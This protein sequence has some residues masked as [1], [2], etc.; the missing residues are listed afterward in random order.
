MRRATMKPLAALLATVPVLLS[1]NMVHPAPATTI[2]LAHYRLT[3]AED[4]NDLSVSPWADGHSRWIA[5]TPWAGDFGDAPFADPAP[6]FPFTLKD[7]VLR[8]E[9]RKDEA[10]AWRAGL[11]S[12][13]DDK[14]RGFCQ[15][16][17]YFE[18][19]MKLPP[20]PG[21]WP[22][23]WLM[24]RDTSQGKAEID[25]M[26]YYGHNNGQIISTWHVWK[27]QPGQSDQG[28][29]TIVAVPPGSLSAQFHTYGVEVT[30]GEVRFY[31]DRRESWRVPAPP[32]YSTCFY[33]LVDL[34]LGSGWPIK[35][36]PSPSY[37]WVDYIHVYQRRPD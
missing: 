31:L 30:P 13:V 22:G 18:A 8:I 26:E 36:T 24:G 28:G 23:F 12:A 14:G 19:R 2:D 11:L 33:P 3:F 6:G 17:G 37:L 20:G 15:Q 35:D 25:V 7:G 29:Q 4:F 32:S 9:A 21:V 10:G 1:G 16:Y 34:A 5:H 27:V